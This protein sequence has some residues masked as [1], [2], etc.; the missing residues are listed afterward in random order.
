MGNICPT[1]KRTSRVELLCLEP[2]QWDQLPVTFKTKMLKLR[3][4]ALSEEGFYTVFVPTSWSDDIH[5]QILK[6]TESVF[7]YHYQAPK[8][9]ADDLNQTLYPKDLF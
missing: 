5:Q 3:L 9:D 1:G 8:E 4:V 7:Y 6:I 2:N